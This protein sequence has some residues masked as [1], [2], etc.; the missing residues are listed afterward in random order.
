MLQFN[1]HGVSGLKKKDKKKKN[2][3]K[4]PLCF[5]SSELMETKMFASAKEM[6]KNKMISENTS[7]IPRNISLILRDKI[8]SLPRRK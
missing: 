8:I 4:S 5:V 6:A 1:K 7:I 2:L 3:Q